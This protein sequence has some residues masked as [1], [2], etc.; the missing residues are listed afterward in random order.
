MM[1]K[2]F[3][4][5]L[6]GEY[7][8]RRKYLVGVSGG[9]DSVALLHLLHEAGFGKLVVCHLNHALRGRAS[10]QDAA[11]VKRLAKNLGYPCEAQ[12]IDVRGLAREQKCSIEVAAR[13]ARHGFFAGA[14][15]KHRCPRLFLGHHADDQVETVLINIFRGSGLRGLAGMRTE[16]GHKVDGV[17]LT[18]L[19]P[20]LSLWR[21]DIDDYLQSHKH[22]YREDASNQ[23]DFVLRNRIRHRLLPDLKRMFERDV[24]KAVYRL[25]HMAESDNEALDML[26]RRDFPGFCQDGQLLVKALR[27]LPGALQRRVIRAWLGDKGIGGAGF[28]DIEEI[29]SLIP[30]G[31]GVAKINLPNHKH[32]RRREGRIF[33]DPL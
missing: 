11:F 19:R 28:R 13:D 6:R 27:P 24:R 20:L 9:R 18:F 3:L 7:S 10:G 16:A 31:S 8:L 33:I 5:K 15:E 17:H 32:V 12:R 25:S 23:S 22:R 21:V 14:A 4:A 1:T 26:I 2:K 30:V 29:R